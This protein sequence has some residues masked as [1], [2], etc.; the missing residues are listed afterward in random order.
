LPFANS[1]GYVPLMDIRSLIED[2]TSRLSALIEQQVLA[3]ARA[4]VDGAL[5]RS[6]GAGGIKLRKRPPRQ[7]CPVPGCKNT[8][9]PVY[10]M[11]CATHKDVPKRQIKKYRDARRAKKLKAAA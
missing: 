5:G 2:F 11:V 9:A 10:G 6:N 3:R 7:L 1:D 8:A 4:A